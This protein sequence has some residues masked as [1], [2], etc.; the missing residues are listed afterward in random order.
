MT[1]IYDLT[2]ASINDEILKLCWSNKKQPENIKAI[3]LQIKFN[4]DEICSSVLIG[5]EKQLKNIITLDIETQY[6]STDPEVGG[7]GH[8]ERMKVAVVCIHCSKD[9]KFH[10]YL[11]KDIP[12]LIEKLKEADLIVGFNIIKFDFAV[13]QPYTDFDLSV[14]PTYDILD[15]VYRKLKYRVSLQNFSETTLGE[16][17]SGDGCQAVQ[18]FR[19]NK[20]EGLIE[21]CKK[22]VALTRNLFYFAKENGYLKYSDKDGSVRQVEINL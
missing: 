16:G 15:V 17:K 2:L 9:D 14:L 20:M 7:W 3:K 11:E 8:P 13:L 4:N 21:Y 19:E 5:K 18:M 1:S 12:E 22:D 6:L 10:S